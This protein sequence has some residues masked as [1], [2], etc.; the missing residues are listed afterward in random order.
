MKFGGHERD[1]V[2]AAPLGRNGDLDYMHA[3]YYNA[4][5][6]RFLSTDPVHGKP[7]LSQSWNAY[8]YVRDNPVSMVDP[9]GRDP[10]FS[11]GWVWNGSRFTY[12]GHCLAY[13]TPAE[14][15]RE[16][17]KRR[18]E[19]HKKGAVSPVA[20]NKPG[21]TAAAGP[22]E[23]GVDFWEV[24][25]DASA[26]SERVNNMAQGLAGFGDSFLDLT[27][28]GPFADE[29]LDGVRQILFNSGALPAVDKENVYDRKS[30]SF[31]IGKMLGWGYGLLVDYAILRG[32]GAEPRGD[33]NDATFRRGLE[34][35]SDLK[36]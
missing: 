11:G 3:R 1:N 24:Y 7:Q 13:D 30:T 29:A 27:P 33:V 36:Y 31:T 25:W 35:S 34:L 4:V 32:K 18:E 28:V 5:A 12:Q 15:A 17:A 22:A 16:E 8:S 21:P 23:G 20:Q 9:D 10:R 2:N 14:L 6:G 19:R 26:Q